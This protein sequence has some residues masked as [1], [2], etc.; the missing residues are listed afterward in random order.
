MNSVLCPFQITLVDNNLTS[1]NDFVSSVFHIGKD[2]TKSLIKITKVPDHFEGG[3]WNIWPSH[4]RSGAPITGTII[5]NSA[6]EAELTLTHPADCDDQ[7]LLLHADIFL[8]GTSTCYKRSLKFLIKR[9]SETIVPTEF[10]F[11]PEDS[12]FMENI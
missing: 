3:Q 5:R 10:V 2:T 1:P 9:T 8:C 6:G 11:N 12:F 7:D 4:N